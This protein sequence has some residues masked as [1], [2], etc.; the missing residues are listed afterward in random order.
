[1]YRRKV[2]STH[3]SSPSSP[4]RMTSFVMPSMPVRKDSRERVMCASWEVGVRFKEMA[5]W[6][7]RRESFMWSAR[8]KSLDGFNIATEVSARRS[9][10][11]DLL[12]CEGL[13]EHV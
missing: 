1:M 7:S 4:R 9:A 11:R 12:C 13:D 8:R 3:A 6:R 2:V 5:R 10:V